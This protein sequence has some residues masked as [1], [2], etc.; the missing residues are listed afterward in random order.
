ML[1]LLDE[2]W[3]ITGHDRGSSFGVRKFM[4]SSSVNIN[5]GFLGYVVGVRTWL[6]AFGLYL[7]M[8]P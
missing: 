5:F 7:Q 3:E 1:L 6:Y 2:Q 8:D 4:P